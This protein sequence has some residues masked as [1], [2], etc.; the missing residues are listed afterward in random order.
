MCTSVTTDVSCLV[1]DRLTGSV[2][3]DFGRLL[4]GPL[5]RP[6]T[7]SSV[8]QWLVTRRM[9]IKVTGTKGPTLIPTITRVS[10]KTTDGRTTVSISSNSSP[11]A[12]IL[13]A[14]TNNH[15]SF[16]TTELSLDT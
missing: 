11:I 15:T 8:I 14:T 4:H 12:T 7:L 16:L 10:L 6:T 3:Y 1:R 13:Y 2:W 9:D 5:T